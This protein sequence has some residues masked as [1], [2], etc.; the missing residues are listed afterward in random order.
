MAK[1]IE[2]NCV[3]KANMESGITLFKVTEKIKYCFF[4]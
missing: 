3:N 2:K 1:N 4:N